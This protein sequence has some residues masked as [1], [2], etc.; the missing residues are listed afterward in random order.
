MSSP[1]HPKN[2][3]LTGAASISNPIDIYNIYEPQSR[4]HNHQFPRK[5]AV[6]SVTRPPLKAPRMQGPP[7]RGPPRAAD[8]A[9][10]PPGG[11]R[12]GLE[13]P[14]HR[15]QPPSSRPRLGDLE[16]HSPEGDVTPSLPRPI[17]ARAASGPIP[18][19]DPREAAG[20]RAGAARAAPARWADVLARAARA[21]AVTLRRCGPARWP[22]VCLRLAREKAQAPP[23]SGPWWVVT[24]PLIAAS[25]AR[26]ASWRSPPLMRLGHHPSVGY[27]LVLPPFS[28]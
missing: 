27:V 3:V 9:W 6:S 11:T 24:R 28:P 12:S 20:P 22:M 17:R 15:Q 8:A 4:T 19:R 10:T 13:A 25:R 14:A 5:S 23:S 18:S 7:T 26:V 21:A 16:E 1:F 2:S